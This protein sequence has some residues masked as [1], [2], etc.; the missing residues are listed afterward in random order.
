MNDTPT[1]EDIANQLLKA[2]PRLMHALGRDRARLAGHEHHGGVL[3]ERRGQF[4]VL[5]TLLDH[6]RMT[7]QDLATRLEI[8]PPTVS[9]M[10]HALAERDLVTRERDESDQRVVWLELSATGRTAVEEERRRMREVFL[11]RF[12]Q[13]GE[14]DRQRIAAAIPALQRLL[15]AGGCRKE[16]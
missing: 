3:R 6:G 9:T 5:H 10:I 16:A 4:R 15:A 1:T 14:D 8:A 12:E 2:L 13:L 7:T 11:R